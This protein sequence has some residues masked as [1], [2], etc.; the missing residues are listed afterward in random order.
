MSR[1]QLVMMPSRSTKRQLLPTR[2]QLTSLTNA[3]TSAI[4]RTPEATMSR[5]FDVTEQQPT[6]NR[7]TIR[8][9]QAFLDALNFERSDAESV[10]SLDKLRQVD[11][12][13]FERSDVKSAR[14]GL[15]LSDV[16]GLIYICTITYLPRGNI[17][18]FE[19]LFFYL[20]VYL[21]L[22]KKNVFKY[23]PI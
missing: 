11:S 1:G 4:S 2:Q 16:N 10:L 7:R 14:I 18:Y 13:N 19:F 15:S 22:I 9:S 21:F 20:E 6:T 23:C 8:N 12:L 17:F 3:P 5:S